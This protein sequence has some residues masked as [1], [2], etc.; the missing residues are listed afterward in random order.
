VQSVPLP[1]KGSVI[2]PVWSPDGVRLAFEVI[3]H[4]NSSI[5]DYNTQNHGLLIITDNATGSNSA[6]AVLTLDW[7][8]DVNTPTITWSVGVI[9]HVHSLWE[10]SVGE[11]ESPQPVLL[12]SGDFVQASYSRSGHGGVGSWLIVTSLA[13]RAA[14]LWRIDIAPGSMMIPLTHAKQ[15][16][17]AQWSPDGMDVD[18]LDALSAGVGTFHVVNVATGADALIAQSVADDPAPAWSV[19][20]QQLVYNTGTRTGIVNLQAGDQ[21]LYLKLR[22]SASAFIWSATSPHQLV[23]AL[24]DGQPGIYLVDTQHN[25]LQQLDKEGASGP[26]TWTE[27]P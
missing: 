20:S 11:S 13:G 10:R 19:D 22:G 3:A 12:L 9:G 2:N 15:V 1:T 4:G 23:V 26:L 6:D 25:A 17:Y 8:P 5:L 21:T 16:S 14:D 18:Y 27:I 24:S 7:S